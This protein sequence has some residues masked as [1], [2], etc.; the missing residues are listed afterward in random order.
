[1]NA[2]LI[3]I[4]SELTSGERLDTNTQWLSQ[5]LNDLGFSVRFQTTIADDLTDMVETFRVAASRSEVVTITGGLGPTQDDLTREALAQ[6]AGVELQLDSQAL[7][8]IEAYFRGRGRR[9]PERNRL[10]AMCPQGAQLLENPHGTAPGLYFP[11]SEE[12]S[13]E[14]GASCQLFAM[15]GVPYEMKKMWSEQVVPRLPST[16]R[17]IKR[18][19]I[20]LFG[21]GESHCEELLGDLTT[22]GRDPEVGITVHQ[23][24]IVL[25]LA[26]MGQT[27]QEC[28]E[29]LA[30][31]RELIASRAAEY[32]FGE[33]EDELETPVISN[34]RLRKESVTTVEVGPVAYLQRRLREQ[35]AVDDV[36]KPG[37]VQQDLQNLHEIA[38][39]ME[40]VRVQENA[41]YA[42]G[43][44]PESRP[45]SGEWLQAVLKTP[46]EIQLERLAC[47]SDQELSFVRGAKTAVNLLRKHLG[48]QWQ[49]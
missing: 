36:L 17:L 43:L 35:N 16:G 21:L 42:L 28:D 44:F 11:Y 46:E 33:E 9:M 47:F 25:R 1:M 37:V 18:H 32:I 45:H 39:L 3:A 20:N 48:H 14:Q 31:T 7:E 19:R 10:Q 4:G 41:T 34:L 40:Q 12:L 38:E 49:L 5:Q 29:K 8:T 23:A 27:H 30:Q 13:S 22:R 2:E 24:T 6:M 15:P 26:A